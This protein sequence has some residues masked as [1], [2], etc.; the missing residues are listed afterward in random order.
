MARPSCAFCFLPLICN[1]S[2]EAHFSPV[3]MPTKLHGH[4]DS[5]GMENQSFTVKRW[6]V[7]MASAAQTNGML[8]RNGNIPLV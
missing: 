8:H 4:I 6:T 3:H 7:V 1:P 5:F 2:P